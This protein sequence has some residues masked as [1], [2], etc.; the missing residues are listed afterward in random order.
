[1]RS[2]GLGLHGATFPRVAKELSAKIVE[3]TLPSVLTTR[4]VQTP[5]C[6][7]T[8]ENADSIVT[9]ERFDLGNVAC[10]DLLG[11]NSKSPLIVTEPCQMTEISPLMCTPEETAR[12]TA[13]PQSWLRP[14]SANSLSL[15]T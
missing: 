9:R 8:V 7:A 14:V 5:G 10:L 13:V 3:N 12:A 6:R 4:T 2:S 1:M 11:A 15:P